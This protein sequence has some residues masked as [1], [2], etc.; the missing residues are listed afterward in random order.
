EIACNGESCDSRPSTSGGG[1]H[2]KKN[3]KKNIES[4]KGPGSVFLIW[5][6][7]N[8]RCSSVCGPLNRNEAIGDPLMILCVGIAQSHACPSIKRSSR[9]IEFILRI[10]CWH[11]A[12]STYGWR[13][14]DD[15]PTRQ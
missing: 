2:E 10:S 1:V 8:R 5:S 13:P 14:S 7:S 12:R 9:G 6:T 4:A 3:E 11:Q 15:L